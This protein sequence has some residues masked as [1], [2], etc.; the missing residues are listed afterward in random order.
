MSSCIF[1]KIIAGEV[2][3]S[4][5]FEDAHTI[6]FMDLGQV[7]PG[8]VIVAVKP[9]VENIYGLSDDLAAAVFRTAAKVARAVKAT[10][11]AQGMTLLQA[12]EKAGWQTVFHFH[13]HVVPRHDNDGLTF[14]WPVKNPPPEELERLAAKVRQK[15]AVG[16][17]NAV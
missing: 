15:L 13:L 9:H 1:C 5:V 17:N 2:P 6:A 11:H 16:S 7:N 3:A 12:N 4:K 8:H 10:M 14:S